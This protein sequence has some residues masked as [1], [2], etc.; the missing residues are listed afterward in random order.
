MKKLL[1]GFAE[2]LMRCPA[3]PYHE[4]LV[5]AEVMRICGE[6]GLF[7]EFDR[8]GNLLVRCT[9]RTI[10]SPIALAAHMD[11]PGFVVRKR[12]S[13]GRYVARFL[14]GVG[15]SYFRAGT[16][17]LLMPGRVRARLGK[18]LSQ[19]QRDFEIEAVSRAAGETFIPSFAIWDLP[20]FGSRKG[21]LRGRVC[22]DLIG[23]ATILAVLAEL[24]GT[25]AGSNVVGV[26]TRAEEVGF[27][28]ALMVAES[29][30][31]PRESLV[32]SLET[33]R[34]LPGV[35][36]GRGVILRVGDKASIFDSAA[37]RFLAEV[38]GALKK[39]DRTFDFQRALMSGGTCEATAYQEYGYRCAA[40]CVALGN[41]HNCGAKDKI[42]AEYVSAADAIS[43]G[44]L[45]AEAARNLKRFDD[46]A[47]RLPKR[48]AGL[49]REGKRE[50]LKRRINPQTP[51]K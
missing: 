34:E 24:R 46:L 15:D 44:K 37:T 25:K 51:R 42:A 27:Q 1:P 48:L 4:E 38:G 9:K 45:L 20:E 13:Q 19:K 29:K 36:M 17:L 50:L 23:V 8:Y 5:A 39:R 49:A 7:H 18:R 33:S 32:I 14:G 40:V 21:I 6:H 3:A 30:S 41:Y 2:R 10:K 31:I 28:G 11:H 12:V 47:G 43:M 26:L 35:K 22:D 16:R